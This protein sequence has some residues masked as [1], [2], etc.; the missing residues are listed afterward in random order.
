MVLEISKVVGMVGGAVLLLPGMRVGRNPKQKDW[1]K[2]EKSLD[3]V[4]E[5]SIPL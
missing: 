5:I 1:V 3:E 4:V 2:L